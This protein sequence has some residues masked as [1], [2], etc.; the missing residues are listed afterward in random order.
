MV[1]TCLARFLLRMHTG[2][3]VVLMPCVLIRYAWAGPLPLCS[4]DEG[5]VSAA[6][7]LGWTA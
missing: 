1:F 7:R 6:P 3:N 5:V 4:H 2:F